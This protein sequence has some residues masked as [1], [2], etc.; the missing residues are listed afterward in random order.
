MKKLAVITTHPVQYHVPWLSRLVEKDIQVKVF[1]TWEQS[2]SGMIF[3]AGFGKSFQWDIPLLEGYDFEF[4]QNVAR[5]PGLGHFKGIVNPDLISKIED[6]GAEGVL[7]IGWNFLSHLQAMRHFHGRIPVYFRGDSVLMHEKPGPRRWAR[8]IFLTW[9]YRHVDFA[10][11]VGRNNKAYFL[12]HGLRHSQ[13]IFS[14]Q[15]I[16]IER[17][18]Q[19]NTFY[20]KHAQDRRRD[21]GIPA[22]HVTV[23]FAGKLTAV[24]NPF[25]I[26]E[27]ADACRDLPV[28]FILVGDGKL[29]MALKQRCKGKENV[30][31][32]EF[33]NQRAMPIVYRMGDIY[34]MPSLSETWGIGINEAMSCGIPVIAAD[35]VGCAADLVLENVTGITIGTGNIKKCVDFIRMAC[36]DRDRLSEMGRAAKSLIQLFSFTQ[37]IDSVALAMKAAKISPNKSEPLLGQTDLRGKAQNA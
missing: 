21:L 33:Q 3:D 28:H 19:P 36:E 35:T 30:V 31:F 11:Y 4:L 22:H 1:Y 12:R 26:A 8:R 14:P 29:K 10:L 15:A 9:V 2:K 24:K 34:I 13:M 25:F 17:F 18:S 32:M 16:D 5:R 27:L 37:V 7:V 20:T 6:W 23:L